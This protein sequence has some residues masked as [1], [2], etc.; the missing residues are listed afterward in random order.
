M[1]GR[2]LAPADNKRSGMEARPYNLACL[3]LIYAVGISELKP[4]MAGQAR[5][6]KLFF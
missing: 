2:G 3:N 6:D 5:H 4:E 1:V